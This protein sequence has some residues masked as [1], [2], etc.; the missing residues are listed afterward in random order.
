MRRRWLLTFAAIIAI[1]GAGFG[2]AH[3]SCV[4]GQ[5]VSHSCCQAPQPTNVDPEHSCC[6]DPDSEV[7]LQPAGP[8]SGT[9][10]CSCSHDPQPLDATGVADATTSF[11]VGPALITAHSLNS[12]R[13]SRGAGYAAHGVPVQAHGPPVFLIDCAFLI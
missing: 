6:S 3:G 1:I 4:L 13:S 8:P 9:E 2:S 11:K 5:G 10:A 12:D 7:A